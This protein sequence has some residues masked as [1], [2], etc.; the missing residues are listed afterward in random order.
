MY[1]PPEVDLLE[2]L[3]A[4]DES[5]NLALQIFLRVYGEEALERARHVVGIYVKTGLIELVEVSSSDKRVLEA[6]QIRPV[7][8]DEVNWRPHASEEQ[9]YLLRLTQKG[10]DAFVRDSEGFFK[11][12]FAKQ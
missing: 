12:L 11:R 6:W 7:L 2:T 3:T 4:G 10:Y 5:L 8:A 9:S 1:F